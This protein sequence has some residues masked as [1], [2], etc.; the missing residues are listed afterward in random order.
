[1]DENCLHSGSDHPS[2]YQLTQVDF[3]LRKT[4]SLQSFSNWLAK[5]CQKI[6]TQ[7]V[8]IIALTIYSVNFNLWH[9]G[10]KVHQVKFL[11]S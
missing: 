11:T 9:F 1:M 8:N 5:N 10:W 2:F 3:H 6:T 4:S 7:M